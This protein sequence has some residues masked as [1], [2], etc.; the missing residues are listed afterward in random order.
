MIKRTV[1]LSGASMPHRF[2]ALAARFEGAAMR[3]AGLNYAVEQIT[4]LISRGVRGVHLYTMNKGD[5]ATDVF[6]RIEKVAESVR[7]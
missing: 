7:A 1:E 5:V 3:E 2:T 6:S 4:E